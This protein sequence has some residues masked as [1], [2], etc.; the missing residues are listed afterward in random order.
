MML[1]E[2]TSAR[3]RG[4]AAAVSGSSSSS[5]AGLTAASHSR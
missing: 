2:T 3:D 5:S 1:A 4:V